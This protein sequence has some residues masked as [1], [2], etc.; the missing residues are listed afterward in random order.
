[1]TY[2]DEIG[3]RQHNWAKEACI[4]LKGSERFTERTGRVLEYKAKQE[5]TRQATLLSPPGRP[6][7]LVPWQTMEAGDSLACLAL[8]DLQSASV[9]CKM[10]GQQC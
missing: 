1:M 6:P 3:C 4:C 7:I 8:G 10:S 2:Y 5:F 9:K